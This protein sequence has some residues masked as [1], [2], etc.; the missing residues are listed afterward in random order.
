LLYVD[1]NGSGVVEK[2]YTRDAPKAK[3]TSAKRKGTTK[4]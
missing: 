4:K 2:T 1:F 3:T